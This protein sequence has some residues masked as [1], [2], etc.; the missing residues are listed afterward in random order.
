MITSITSV[1]ISD[2]PRESG[3]QHHSECQQLPDG[4][5]PQRS[6]CVR[7]CRSV[8]LHRQ[9]VAG[10]KRRQRRQ[11]QCRSVCVEE[12]SVTVKQYFHF[13]AMLDFE[14]WK[15]CQILSKE[16]PW[17]LH[18]DAGSEVVPV[19]WYECRNSRVCFAYSS[20]SC[21]LASIC[22]SWDHVQHC[23]VILILLSSWHL[24]SKRRPACQ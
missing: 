12:E 7:C 1:I 3:G 16:T 15:Q 14:R 17:Q 18:I 13:N 11:R 4:L 2:F 5:S 23:W 6:E 19:H 8:H 22:A 10:Q 9:A 21:G 20:D 24:Q